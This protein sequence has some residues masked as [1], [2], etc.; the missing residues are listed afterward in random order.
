MKAN[1]PTTEAEGKVTTGFFADT[2]RRSIIRAILLEALADEL[3]DSDTSDAAVYLPWF[4]GLRES[5]LYMFF[6]PMQ[7]AYCARMVAEN[8]AIRRFVLSLSDR[9]ETLF[10]MSDLERD[11]MDQLTNAVLFIQREKE[12]EG[13]LIPRDVAAGVTLTNELLSPML[14]SNSWLTIL[15]LY[16]ATGIFVEVTTAYTKA[17]MSA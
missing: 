16:L 3:N 14:R 9:V 7:T 13:S 17:G 10:A 6:S 11:I 4:E 12:H 2:D 1:N 5:G 8:L 15:Y